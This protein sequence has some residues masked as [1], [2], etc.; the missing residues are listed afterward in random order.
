MCAFVCVR[1]RVKV[2][3]AGGSVHVDGVEDPLC[4]L[5]QLGGGCLRLLLQPLVVLPQ[6]LDLPLQ[7]QLLLT[8]LGGRMGDIY[9]IEAVF[10]QC[11]TNP[12]I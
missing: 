3:R 6:P 4:E 12:T 7:P 2:C 11:N 9:T 8:L 5:L 10:K 1:A